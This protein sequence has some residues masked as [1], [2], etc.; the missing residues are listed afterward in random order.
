MG[1]GVYIVSAEPIAADNTVI[2]DWAG[3]YKEDP[4]L[5]QD[6]RCEIANRIL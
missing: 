5:L 3:I 2:R 4:L 1:A 6:V